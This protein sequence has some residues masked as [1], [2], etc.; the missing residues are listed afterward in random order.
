[1]LFSLVKAVL[2]RTYYKVIENVDSIIFLFS[3]EVKNTERRSLIRL[4]NCDL[5][6]EADP[7]KDMIQR[8]II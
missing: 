8:E 4:L 2:K 3:R 6:T 7:E 1:M 5:T